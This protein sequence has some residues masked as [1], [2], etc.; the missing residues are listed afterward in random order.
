[1]VSIWALAA[2]LGHAA[3]NQDFK[4]RVTVYT[5][6]R[7]SSNDVT[8]T[9]AKGM[10]SQM[11]AEAGVR[12]TWRLGQPRAD[13][14]EQAIVIQITS[15]TPAALQPGALA[16]AEPFE[17]VHIRVF[18]DRIQAI[19]ESR[20]RGFGE[21]R[22][23]Q[24]LLAHVLVHEITHILQGTARHSPQGIMKAHWTPG[25]LL[26]MARH[27]LPFDPS[28]VDLI[29]LG[30]ANRGRVATRTLLATSVV[31]SATPAR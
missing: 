5:D 31:P 16:Y 10:A 11:F 14:V 15:K 23:T 26:E 1:M 27:P 25:D 19:G 17:G 6:W 29:H 24:I 9:L 21:S 3:A 28:D 12:L 4:Q 18:Y 2:T 20:S 13:E 7:D 8:A 30:L 22:F